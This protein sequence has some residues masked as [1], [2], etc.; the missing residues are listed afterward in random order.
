MEEDFGQGPWLTMKSALGLDERDPSCFL[1]TYSIVMVLRKVRVW[2]MS[3]CCLLHRKEAICPLLLQSCPW[4]AAWSPLGCLFALF[5]VLSSV[6]HTSALQ[7]PDRETEVKHIPTLR[8]PSG[9]L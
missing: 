8:T 3:L 2:G 7:V 4:R 1:Y 9:L 6:R 5:T